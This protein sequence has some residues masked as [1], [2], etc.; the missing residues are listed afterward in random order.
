MSQSPKDAH[1]QKTN[2]MR[3]LEVAHIP[4]EVNIYDVEDEVSV[5]IGVRVAEACGIDPDSAFKTLVCHSGK[6]SYAV[7]CIPVAHDLDLKKAARAAHQKSLELLNIKDLYIVTGYVRGGCS[8]VG[9]KKQYPTFIDETAQLY[10]SIG[11]SGGKIGVQL[12]MNPYDLAEH[13]HAEFVDL[14][15]S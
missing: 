2:A 6:S 12:I 11:I 13:C 4:Y 15:E 3:E 1:L 5:G 10:D 9:M 8:P 14:V 7:F